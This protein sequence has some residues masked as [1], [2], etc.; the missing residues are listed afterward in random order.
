MN[1]I[2]LMNKVQI[3]CDSMSRQDCFL[4]GCPDNGVCSRFMV[5]PDFEYLKRGHKCDTRK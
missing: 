2:Q 5:L 4:S 1:K 3:K